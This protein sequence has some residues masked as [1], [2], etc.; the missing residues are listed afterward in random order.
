MAFHQAFLVLF[1]LAAVVRRQGTAT[2][3]PMPFT[4]PGT[5]QLP[6]ASGGEERRPPTVTTD[7]GV[8]VE[9][10]SAE[11]F[12]NPVIDQD[13]ADPDAL[14]VG[15]TY[16][17][18]ATN[19]RKINVQVARS[20]D[21]VTWELLGEAMPVLPTWA[22]ARYTWAPDVT[23]SA[24]GTKYVMYFVARDRASRKQVVGVAVSDKPDGPFVPVGDKPLVAQIEEGG[25]IDPHPFVAG[26]G[27]PWL[28]WKNNDEFSPAVSK[29]WAAPLDSAG[30]GVVSPP[31]EVMAK[32]SQRYPWQTTVDNPQMVV[33]G[34]V[35]YLFYSAGYWGD[36]TYATGYAVCSG[37]TGPCQ[38]GAQPILTS[39]GSV[40]GPGGGTVL[41][42]ASGRW[43]LS[44]HAWSSGCTNYLCGGKRRL[45]VAPL[46]FR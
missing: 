31:V 39:Y 20:K 8:V 3:R 35:H 42:D 43:W 36:G 21:L 45:Y 9:D 11:M 23:V 41:G 27:R 40:A 2:E 14:K 30:T 18:Y 44:Y 13:F 1:G 19:T 37:P 16:Y 7:D 26:D 5:R 10:L 4:L 38:S 12:M 22:R 6:P 17:A 46:E 33:V 15:D 25:S 29:V 34:G 28:H 32:D 24:D